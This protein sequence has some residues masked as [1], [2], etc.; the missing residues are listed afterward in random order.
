MP[1][2][3]YAHCQPLPQE[4]V[5]KLPPGP[6]NTIVVTIDNRVVRLAQATLEILDVFDVL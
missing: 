5:V 4:V 3:V 2:D 6:P 1:A